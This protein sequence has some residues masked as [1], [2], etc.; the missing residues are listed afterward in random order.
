MTHVFGLFSLSTKEHLRSVSEDKRCLNKKKR[1]LRAS[2][3]FSFVNFI[4]LSWA[5]RFFSYCVLVVHNRPKLMTREEVE[6]KPLLHLT[7]TKNA[8]MSYSKLC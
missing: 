8:L 5:G 7:T 3:L 4:K 2:R 6:F 1:F